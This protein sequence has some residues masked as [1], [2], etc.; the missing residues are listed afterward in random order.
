MYVGTHAGHE[1]FIKNPSKTHK[2]QKSS[3]KCATCT[4]TDRDS[5]I[6]ASQAGAINY[7]SLAQL[8]RSVGRSLY[9]ADKQ[10]SSCFL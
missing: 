7:L 2:H 5:A 3:E 4:V 8:W 6:F 10:P 9:Y 1:E